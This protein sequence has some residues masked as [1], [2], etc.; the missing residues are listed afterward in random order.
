MATVF[1]LKIII[2]VLN[3]LT[4]LVYT[5][6]IYYSPQCR[7]LIVDIYLT[8]SQFVKKTRLATSTLVNQLLCIS[9]SL[10]LAINIQCK[11]LHCLLTSELAPVVQ[12][13]GN[14]IHW[15]NHYS[16]DSVIGFPNTYPLDSDLSGGY[17]YPTFEQLGPDQQI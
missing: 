5:K 1:E 13:V 12:N 10:K 8:A 14:A 6:T 9:I 3:Y 16:L 4:V 2:F 15:I 7:W 17:C 11:F